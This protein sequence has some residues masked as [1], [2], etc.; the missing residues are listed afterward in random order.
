VSPRGAAPRADLAAVFAGLR[1][2]MARHAGSFVV[3]ADTGDRYMV[4]AGWS[5]KRRRHINA[6]GVVLG[7][8]Y[9]SYHLIPVYA[10]PD[11]VKGL[12]PALRQRMQG[13]SCFNF[14]SLEPVQ[15]RELERVTREGFARFRKLTFD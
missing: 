4:A 5:E 9:V 13:K 12:S 7:K 15:V 2:I 1:T 10:F 11:L 8:N 3:E 14:T 6:G